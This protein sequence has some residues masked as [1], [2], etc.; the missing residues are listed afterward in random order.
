MATWSCS[1]NLRFGTL[2]GLYALIHD[3]FKIPGF[4]SVPASSDRL[5]AARR[6]GQYAVKGAAARGVCYLR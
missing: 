3:S 2:T 6:Q 4:L 1:G 5:G